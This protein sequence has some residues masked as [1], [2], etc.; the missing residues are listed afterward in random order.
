MQ[1]TY[2][3]LCQGV[4]LLARVSA[5]VAVVLLWTG[6][7]IA[8][9]ACEA[10]VKVIDVVGEPPVDPDP[11]A[12]LF[13]DLQDAINYLSGHLPIPGGTIQ[14]TGTCFRL[15]E[16]GEEIP[17]PILVQGFTEKLTIEGVLDP[18]PAD[19]APPTKSTLMQDASC[20]DDPAPSS[21]V[22]HIKDSSNVH[23]KT[24][25]INGGEG[26]SVENSDVI[27]DGFVWV[28]G[29]R[30]N[31]VEIT[32]STGRV[33][34]LG[35]DQNRIAENCQHGIFVGS[36]GS[37]TVA[38][39]TLIEH[40]GAFGVTGRDGSSLTFAKQCSVNNNG[41]GGANARFGS[42]I[43]ITG[44][45]IFYENGMA[46]PSTPNFFFPR[47]R[48]GVSVTAGSNLV[49]FAEI[50]EGTPAIF[51][52]AGPGILLDLASIG[53]LL[54]MDVFRNAQGFVAQSN[55]TAEFLAEFGV[56]NTLINNNK[57]SLTIALEETKETKGNVGGDLVCDSTS[58]IVGDVTGAENINCSS[59]PGKGA[60]I[61]VIN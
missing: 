30:I 50:D 51:D 31:G 46:S 23:L 57:K 52:N 60:I 56:A 25:F 39:T 53:R 36:Q 37:L 40:N 43:L 61:E 54:G 19:G 22:L 58:V 12:P 28:T 47:F 14:V 48:S 20:G 8:Q 4:R 45:S 34:L 29:S 1:K 33:R 55:S 21:A 49:I 24:L 44:H 13:D 2:F 35:N 5:L 32:G 18:E 15:D 10:T 26:V 59:A 9:D 17:E 42:S 16:D 27:F 41:W 7:A 6:T 38:G 11:P 3:E